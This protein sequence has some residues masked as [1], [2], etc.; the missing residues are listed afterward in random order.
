VLI[1]HPSRSGTRP[2]QDP[3]FTFA[4]EAVKEVS[5]FTYL[6]VRYSNESDLCSSAVAKLLTS[7]KNAVHGLRSRCKKLGL[8]DFAVRLALFDAV[9]TPHLSTGCEVWCP[10]VLTAQGEGPMQKLHRSFLRRLLGV[11]DTT[12]IPVVMAEAAAY[13]LTVGWTISLARYWNRL[14]SMGEDRPARW[15]FDAQLAANLNGSWIHHT[16]Q[17][18]A[19]LGMH[20][21]LGG[22]PTEVDVDAVETAVK[23]KFL[24]AIQLNPPPKSA[25]YFQTVRGQVTVD[26]YTVPAYLT[27][28]DD[29]RCRKRLTQV[30]TGSHWFAIETGRFNNVPR[31]LRTCPH[32]PIGEVETAEHALLR[33]PAYATV[34]RNYP[35]IFGAAPPTTLQR[36]LQGE[37]QSLVAAYVSRCADLAQRIVA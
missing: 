33:C 9:I 14:V 12:P 37:P 7:G 29:C 34:R 15:A 11:R 26:S 30:R 35:S 24:R 32:C 13:P 25:E 21:M 10:Q 36:L 8:R 17:A 28:V 23:G 22:A 27:E 5:E 19:R 2:K 3:P 16:R 1:F 20:P 6:G 18:L 4:G 31:E